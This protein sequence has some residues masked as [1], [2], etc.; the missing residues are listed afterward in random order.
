[1]IFD[2]RSNKDSGLPN[3]IRV[4]LREAR[5][6]LVRTQFPQHSLPLWHSLHR[7]VEDRLGI[8]TEVKPCQSMNLMIQGSGLL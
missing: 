8:Q 6:R 5:R 7:V 3:H 1:M 4:I 2:I